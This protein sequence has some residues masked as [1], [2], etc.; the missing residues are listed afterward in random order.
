M[1][2]SMLHGAPGFITVE[3][4]MFFGLG[5]LLAVLLMLAF[6]PAVHRRAVRLTRRKYE[7]VPLEQKEMHA[8]KDRL[9]ADFAISTSKLEFE[10]EKM[11]RKTAAHLTE[12]A[13][14]SGAIAELKKTL[15]ARDTLIADLQSQTTQE[16]LAVRGGMLELHTLRAEIANKTMA[17]QKADQRIVALMTEVN[18]LNAALHKRGQAYDTQQR[19]IAALTRQSDA[20][21]RELDAVSQ[22]APIQP[23]PPQPAPRQPATIPSPALVPLPQADDIRLR[24]TKEDGDVIRRALEAIQASGIQIHSEEWTNSNGAIPFGH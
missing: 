4:V 17:L 2:G 19:E 18:A 5:F 7:P 24:E 20:L 14:K 22:P 21:R 16:A 9:R 1:G 12:I 3:I 11:Q 15:D 10:I 6:M 23:A 8:E 13:K